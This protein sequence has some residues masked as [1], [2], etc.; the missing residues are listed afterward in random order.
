MIQTKAGRVVSLTALALFLVL[1]LSGCGSGATVNPA[2]D[3]TVLSIEPPVIAVGSVVATN[4]DDPS[5]GLMICE[6]LEVNAE[7]GSHLCK[8][9]D[10]T[11][12]YGFEKASIIY[13][14][15]KQDLS[16]AVGE[17]VLAARN[18][19]WFEKG[20]VKEVKAGS[21]LVT[22]TES[23]DDEIIPVGRFLP[24]NLVKSSFLK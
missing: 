12:S 7:K 1:G 15:P 19:S 24:I 3:T 16:L 20:T 11:T 2:Q 14:V 5:V 22:F 4:D 9:P 23:Q 18:N 6:L 8:Y 21:Y 17:S 10:G 13:S